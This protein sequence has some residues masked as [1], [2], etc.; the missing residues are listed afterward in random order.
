MLKNIKSEY[1][2]KIIFM[3]LNDYQQLKLIKYNKYLQNKLNIDLYN[4]KIFKG[5]Y[6][7]YDTKGKVKEYFYDGKLKFEGEYS[8]GKRNGKGKEYDDEY[9]YLQFEGEYLN[10]KRNGKGKEYYY[11]GN[12][13][14]EGEYSFGEKHGKGKEYY[15]NGKIKFEGEYKYG[16]R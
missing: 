16:L 2:I 11:N 1:F 15:D 12:I 4:Y 14:F 8:N 10:G 7:E 3:H 13:K 6:L 5:T 9:G